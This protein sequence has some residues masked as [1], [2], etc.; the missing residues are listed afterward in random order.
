MNQYI[1]PALIALVLSGLIFFFVLPRLSPYILGALSLM[2]LV[3][4]IWQHY[5]MFPYEYRTS[6]VTELL[7]QY[8]GFIMLALVIL[9]STIGILM[10]HGTNLPEVSQ[11]IPELPAMPNFLPGNNAKNNSQ[12]NVFNFG[13]NEPKA[14]AAPGILAAPVAAANAAANAVTNA[15]TNAYNGMMNSGRNNAKKNNLASPSFKV[16]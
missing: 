3:L 10:V 11:V 1:G 9:A 6:I 12:K 15:V 7:Q 5:S 14:N 4:G 13:G 2:M 8:A 16:V